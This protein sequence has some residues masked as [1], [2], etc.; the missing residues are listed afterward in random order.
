MQVRRGYSINISRQNPSREL[1]KFLHNMEKQRDF[2]MVLCCAV[3]NLCCCGNVVLSG[4]CQNDVN[5]NL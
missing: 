2:S 3:I 1:R 5:V 4:P